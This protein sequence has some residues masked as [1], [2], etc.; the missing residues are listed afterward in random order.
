MVALIINWVFG[1]L[2]LVLFACV[3]PGFR[4][5][6][7]QSLLLAGALV[8]LISAVMAMLFKQVTSPVGLWIS[9]ILLLL[10]D[11]FLFRVVAL[12][13]PGFAMRGFLPAFA[14]ALLLVSLHL[15]LL[16]VMKART[17][18]AEVRPLVHF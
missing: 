3:S 5:S 7:F 18:P 12:V 17:A 14:G 10:F 16:R 15:I 9:G 6:E 1:A 4:V 11:T 13:V 2:A 8:G